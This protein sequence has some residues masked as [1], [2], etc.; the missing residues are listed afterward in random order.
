MKL[1]KD[2]G[3]FKNN[4]KSGCEKRGMFHCIW[5]GQVVEKRMD[6]GLRNKS[7]GCMQGKWKTNV[8]H[9]Q[10]KTLLYRKWQSM[11]SRCRKHTN[12]SYAH[13][14]GRGIRV[15]VEWKAFENFRNWA[16]KNGYKKG[17]SIERIDNDGDYCPQNCSFIPMSRQ[18]RNKQY[19]KLNPSKVKVIRWMWQNRKFSQ[20]EIGMFFNISSKYVSKLVNRG[21]WKDVTI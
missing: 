13:Y 6:A 11:L 7:C 10:T 15:C 4:T 12:P 2:L 3:S 9:G 16:L 8:K 14:G 21:C 1:V 17:L 18:A 20:K 5:C 19:N